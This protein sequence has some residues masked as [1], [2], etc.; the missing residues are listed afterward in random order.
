MMMVSNGFNF[1][2]NGYYN[3]PKPQVTTKN[4]QEA[5]EYG[6]DKKYGGNGD[7]KLSDTELANIKKTFDYA[8]DYYKNMY[9]QS[10][11][12]KYMAWSD[13][14]SRDS[15]AT[16]N[17]IKNFSVFA[18]NLAT[19]PGGSNFQTGGSNFQVTKDRLNELAGK[20]GDAN[21]ISLNDLAQTRFAGF[22]NDKLATRHYENAVRYG[23][24]KKYG[25]NGDGKL[26]DKEL[27]NIKKTFDYATT[28]YK[29]QAT[30]A[31]TA[32]EKAKFTAWSNYYANDAKAATNIDRESNLFM[33][34]GDPS[35]PVN[36]SLPPVTTPL[37]LTMQR[38]QELAGKD[39][40]AN[41]LSIQDL[42]KAQFPNF[43]GDRPLLFTPFGVQYEEGQP[44]KY[45][46][47]QQPQYGGSGQPMMSDRD[48]SLQATQLA[49]IEIS[50][51]AKQ[52]F[53]MLENVNPESPT[54]Q[55]VQQRLAGLQNED[56]KLALQQQQLSSQPP[57]A[58]QYLPMVGQ[59]LYGMNAPFPTAQDLTYLKAKADNPQAWDGA[60][61][62]QGAISRSTAVDTSRD[63]QISYAEAINSP[64]GLLG[65]GI[66]RLPPDSPQ[67]RAL[68]DAL[69]GPD[70][71]VN[72]QEL[73]AAILSVDGNANGTVTAQEA[74]KFLQDTMAKLAQNPNAAISTYNNFQAGA[75]AFGLDK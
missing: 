28:Y 11:D 12:A 63:G 17:M 70:G 74:D 16:D 43:T 25:G 2:P 69:S 57:M 40:D 52:L 37:N 10:G 48:K 13:H 50:N 29:E 68:W 41:T 19:A 26:D 27:A 59:S 46:P 61:F 32:D 33:Q 21:T 64:D 6:D 1:S 15:K 45:S 44:I 58:G 5:I 75:S 30:K 34:D 42:A 39:G 36:G 31:T 18:T 14:Y 38:V 60:A 66:L 51:L 23:D 9:Q 71:R 73:A 24:D 4:Y 62:A 53:S 35:K 65:N 67:T 20:D 54:A 7:G 47:Q 8:A 56:N 49:R 55:S 22:K 72:P 3:P